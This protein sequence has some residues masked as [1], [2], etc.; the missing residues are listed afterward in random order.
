MPRL[1]LLPIVLFF[2]NTV[3][4]H[5]PVMTCEL[6]GEEIECRVGFSDGTKAVGKTVKLIDYNENVLQRAKADTFS[7]VRFKKPEGEYYLFFDAGHEFPI[8]VDYGEL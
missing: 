6:Q 8:E 7:K 5:Y 3:F 4:A 2:T 1:F